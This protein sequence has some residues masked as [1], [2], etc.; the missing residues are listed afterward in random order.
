MAGELNNAELDEYIKLCSEKREFHQRN[1]SSAMKLHQLFTILGAVLSG[2]TA[3]SM[4]ILTVL[5]S[6]D[7]SIAVI[8]GVFALVIGVTA[9]IQES[10]G[11]KLLNY[12]HAELSNDFQEL[13]N[14]LRILGHRVYSAT[15]FEVLTVKYLAISSRTNVMGTRPCVGG[16]SCFG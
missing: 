5:K 8:G 9:K 2:G 7:V 6:S 16:F 15:E 1:A 14:Q 4:T 10:Y 3:L 11:F 13:E 12:Q